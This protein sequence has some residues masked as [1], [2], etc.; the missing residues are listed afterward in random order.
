MLVP[1]NTRLA[2]P[3]LEFI[4][5]DCGLRALMYGGE[6]RSTVRL[7]QP[8]VNVEHW[9]ALDEPLPDHPSY[10]ELVLTRG[11]G[12]SVYRRSRPDDPLC[13]LHT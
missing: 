13:L 1:L 11:A 10:E 6:Y 5:R 2:V 7:L 12:S 9:I 3:E 8:R 4:I